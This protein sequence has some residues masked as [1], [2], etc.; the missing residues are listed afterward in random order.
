[1]KNRNVPSNTKEYRAWS[2]MINRCYSSA[3]ISYAIYGGRGITVCKR[4]RDSYAAF[5]LDMGACP[6]GCSLDRVD[7]RGNYTPRNC[8][9]A[10]RVTQ[11]VNRRSTILNAEK[12]QAIRASKDHPKVLAER[13]GTCIENIRGVIA[14]VSWKH[15]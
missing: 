10:S 11:N 14:R 5:L 4:W 1:M 3:N 2:G 8:R 6:E 12:V 13:Y 15:V 9:W 7:S